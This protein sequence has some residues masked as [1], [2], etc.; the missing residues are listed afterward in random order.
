[1]RIIYFS[2]PENAQGSNPP[3]GTKSVEKFLEETLNKINFQIY[4]NSDYRFC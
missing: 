4:L 2:S 1:M 3:D